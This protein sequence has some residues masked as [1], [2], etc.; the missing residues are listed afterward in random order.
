MQIQGQVQNSVPQ[1]RASGSPNLMQLQLG[2]IAVSELL[3]RYTALAWSGNL[4]SVSAVG[5]LPAAYAGAAGGTPAIGIYNPP[6]SG[7]NFVPLF[8]KWANTVAASAAGV[9]AFNLWFG[10]TS[11]ITAAANAAPF[12]MLSL[13]QSNSSSRAYTNTALTGAAALT[14]AIP[15]GSYYWATAAGAIIQ[16]GG[17]NELPGGL[18]IPPGSYMALGPNAALTSAA[19]NLFLEWAELPI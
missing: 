9:E 15:L 13:N 3:P 2:E 19:F 11:L 17:Q 14:A 5:V 10:Q 6:N 1:A 12:N 16:D 8:A 4:F 7:H 18:I